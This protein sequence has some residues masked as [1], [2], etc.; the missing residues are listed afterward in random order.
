MTA[1]PKNNEIEWRAKMP[2][3][4]AE[5]RLIVA[6]LG[7]IADLNEHT[8]GQAEQIASVKAA[9]R[10]IGPSRDNLFRFADEARG[11]A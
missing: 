4:K 1:R 2:D 9:R 7:L 5:D 3:E 11:D 8:N 6:I 10:L